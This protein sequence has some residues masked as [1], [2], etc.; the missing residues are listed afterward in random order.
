MQRLLTEL[1]FRGAL[2]VHARLARQAQARAIALHA[3][4]VDL[5]TAI[6]GTGA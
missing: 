3:E 1:E 5:R 6:E 2:D 4:I